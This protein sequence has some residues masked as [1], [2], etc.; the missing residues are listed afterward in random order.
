MLRR[1]YIF[2]RKAEISLDCSHSGKFDTLFNALVNSRSFKS[3]QYLIQKL[4]ETF[5]RT[6]LVSVCERNRKLWVRERKLQL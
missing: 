3:D 2:R 4:L 5:V 6:E 1:L